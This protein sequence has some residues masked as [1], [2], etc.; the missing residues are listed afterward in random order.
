MKVKGLLKLEKHYRI[1]VWS[2]EDSA[3][4]S[5]LE[6]SIAKAYDVDFSI[7]G[8]GWKSSFYV[9]IWEW[10]CTIWTLKIRLEIFFPVNRSISRNNVK[11]DMFKNMSENDWAPYKLKHKKGRSEIKSSS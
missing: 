6:S 4:D 10:K 1:T 3:V 11:T 7:G 8:N 2:C 5:K 9:V